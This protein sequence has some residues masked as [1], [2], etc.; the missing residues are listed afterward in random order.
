M[1][2]IAGCSTAVPVRRP[3]RRSPPIAIDTRRTV[4]GAVETMSSYI[5]ARAADAHRQ[6]LLDSAER[7]RLGRAA[8]QARSPGW[9]TEVIL[10]WVKSVRRK[11]FSD[12]DEL[13]P[14]VP[15]EASGTS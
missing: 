3:R 11:S 15:A 9:R 4:F 5:L 10:N 13:R 12:G 7:Y 2:R 8:S 1:Q 14:A 6:D